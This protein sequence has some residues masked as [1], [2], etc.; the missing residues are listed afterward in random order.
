MHLALPRHTASAGLLRVRAPAAGPEPRVLKT[1]S[2]LGAGGSWRAPGGLGPQHLGRPARAAA[3]GS[4]WPPG[5]PLQLR[6]GVPATAHSA[7]THTHRQ[8]GAAPMAAPGWLTRR[9]LL[10]TRC[11]GCTADGGVQEGGAW[12]RAWP[13]PTSWASYPPC[14]P[15][16][17]PSLG[18]SCSGS[19]P[20][21]A[22]SVPQTR[23]PTEAG[24]EGVGPEAWLRRRGP[25]VGRTLARCS[26]AWVAVSGGTQSV[27]GQ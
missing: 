9:P 27:P 19:Q 20:C 18:P 1:D 4:H 2:D 25:W 26:V 8:E 15:L 11:P 16:P 7:V 14:L 23:V 12:G 13:A 6:E 24:T 17:P 22:L 10:P 3:L 5:A 21:P